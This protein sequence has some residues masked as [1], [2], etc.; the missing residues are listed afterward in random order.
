PSI[1]SPGYRHWERP[2]RVSGG[3]VWNTSDLIAMSL[4]LKR[5]I[6]DV[7]GFPVPGILFR[8]ITPLLADP[9]ALRDAVQR[10][11]EPW[12]GKDIDLIVAMEARGFIFTAP[13]AIELG[14]GFV[15]VRKP[16]KLPWKT[17]R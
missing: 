3:G 15:P 9:R 12:R 2:C 11:A 8:D 14:A 16:G 4:D 7:P 6:R 1:A 13:I 17:R 5:Y 10:M